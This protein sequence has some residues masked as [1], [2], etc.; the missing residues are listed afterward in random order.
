MWHR[1][2]QHFRELQQNSID[3]LRAHIKQYSHFYIF[4]TKRIVN[5]LLR[6]EQVEQQHL[7]NH[8]I[9]KRIIPK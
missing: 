5:T 1:E 7:N 6:I 9:L 4:T 3:L 8:K 2:F